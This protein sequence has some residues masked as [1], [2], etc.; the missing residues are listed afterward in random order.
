MADRVAHWTS[1]PE[2]VVRFI[3]DAA[4]TRAIHCDLGA[5]RR[6]PKNNKRENYGELYP[7]YVVP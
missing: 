2:E 7:K 6:N 3:V 5:V 1:C 4:Y